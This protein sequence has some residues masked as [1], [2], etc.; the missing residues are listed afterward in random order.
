MANI[1]S[2]PGHD[3]ELAAAFTAFTAMLRMRL[4]VDASLVLAERG[5]LTPLTGMETRQKP[6]RLIDKRFV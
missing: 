3:A 2:R 1:N 5:A 4:D 6:V